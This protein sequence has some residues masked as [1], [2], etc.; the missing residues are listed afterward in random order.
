M[1][2]APAKPLDRGKQALVMAYCI[3]AEK[4]L[5]AH[6]LPEARKTVQQ[7]LRLA[8]HHAA[9]ANI[10]GVIEIE[11]GQLEAAVATLARAAKMA[12]AA[13]EPLYFLG[14]A[15]GRLGRLEAAADALNAA[16]ALK[17]ALRPAL[18][19][20]DLLQSLG[21]K[22]EATEAIRRLLALDPGDVAALYQLARHD[23]GQLTE[24]DKA[25]LDAAAAA[26]I[27]RGARGEPAGFALAAVH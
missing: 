21:R 6:R 9:A 11:S 25:R 17:P 14:L 19:V 2:A 3:D 22:A 13:P 23:R 1:S 16:L 4:L 18:H 12:P 26:G 20:V 27:S 10:L 5:L 15:Y 8:P 7:A 24:E